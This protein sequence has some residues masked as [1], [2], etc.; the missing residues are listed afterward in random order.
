[1][2]SG[3]RHHVIEP[4]FAM[5]RQ[6]RPDIDI[7]ILPPVGTTAARPPASAGDRERSIS[8]VR[9]TVGAIAGRVPAGGAEEPAWEA[10]GPE[11]IRC[12]AQISVGT[13]DGGSILDSLDAVFR[14]AGWHTEFAVKAYHRWTAT[15]PEVGIFGTWS[16]H[17][18]SLR[19]T[20]TGR[21]LNAE[22]ESTEAP[23]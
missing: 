15:H 18:N 10:L 12:R 1:M 13:T 11:G 21:L 20:V 5:L 4:F 3:E 19:I 9:T 17:H 8:I 22:N 2:S 23:S 16:E 14:Q 7:V 6:R